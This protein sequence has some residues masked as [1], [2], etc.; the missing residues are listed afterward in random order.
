MSLAREVVAIGSVPRT[1]SFAYRLTVEP[2]VHH[3]W[4]PGMIAWRPSDPVGSAGIVLARVLL[5]II[6]AGLC[7]ICSRRRGATMPLLGGPLAIC[8][9]HEGCSSIRGHL[10]SFV[11]AAVL[12]NSLDLDRAGR[13]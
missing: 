8:S 11:G 5:C 13:R 9:A 1:H 4:N 7:W 10:Y 3:E 2:V 12:L 6:L